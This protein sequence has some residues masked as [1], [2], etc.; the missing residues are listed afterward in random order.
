MVSVVLG[1]SPC[2]AFVLNLCQELCAVSP[3]ACGDPVRGHHL[4]LTDE[5]MEARTDASGVI[6]AT[7]LLFKSQDVPFWGPSVSRG[8]GPKQAA[9][10]QSWGPLQSLG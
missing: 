10:G 1:L 2:S 9:L 4:C 6:S 5:G 3:D 8:R 7:L